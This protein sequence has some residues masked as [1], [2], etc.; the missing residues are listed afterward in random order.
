MS[1][2]RLLSIVA[3]M[4]P[5]AWDAIIPHGPRLGGASRGD[6]VALNPQPLPPRDP[7]LEGAAELAHEAVRTAV[8]MSMRGESPAGFLHE[9]V[10]DWCDTPWPRKWPWPW[11]GPRPEEGPRPEP[12]QVN[13]GR[14]VGAVIFASAGTRIADGELQGTLIE[15]AQRLAETAVSDG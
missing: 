15:M 12:W 4:P 1:Y 14:V 9:L 13:A 8:G 5:A 2:A 11:P 10:A 6:L 7:F 3:R